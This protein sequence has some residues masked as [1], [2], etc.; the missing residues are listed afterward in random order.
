MGANYM[1]KILHVDVESM[2]SLFA[3]ALLCSV[4][5]YGFAGFPFSSP[6]RLNINPTP[7]LYWIFIM[8]CLYN[9]ILALV[10]S[11]VLVLLLR[12]GGHQKY[13]RWS[14]HA[15]NTVN[16]MLMVAIFLVVVF[17]QIPIQSYWDLSITPTRTIDA[18]TFDIVTAGITV[19]T[20]V[21]VLAIPIWLFLGLQMR[22]ATKIG[23][24]LVFLSSGV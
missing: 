14:I 16:L 21:I 22:L 4:F 13:A 12:I 20:D 3:N 1:C 24:I 19:V 9:P 6:E 2:L 23:L 5:R 11:S 8:Q 15:V 18:N 17:Q 10:K 7:M